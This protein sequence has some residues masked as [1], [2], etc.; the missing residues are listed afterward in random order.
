VMQAAQMKP[1]LFFGVHVGAEQM[2]S[3]NPVLVMILVPLLTWGLYPLLESLGFRVTPLRR[4]STGLLVG[5]LSFVIVGWLQRRLEAGEALSLASQTW[6]YIIL[7]A[8]EVLV[9]TTGL[10][11]AYTQAAPS[12]KSAIM[13]FWLLTTSIGNLLVAT[14]TQLGGEHGNESVTSG[15]FFLYAGMMAVVGALFIIVAARYRYR[16]AAATQGT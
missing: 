7:T 3:L 10:E 15:R 12:M 8:S 16:D 1:F 13:S 4:I 14:I 2:Q 11:F 6:P 9:S 5:A